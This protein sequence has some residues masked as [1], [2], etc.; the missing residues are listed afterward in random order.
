[1][2]FKKGAPRPANAGIKKGQT[3]AESKKRTVREIVE[4]CLGKTIPERL[5]E[6]GKNHPDKEA[7]ILEGLMPYTY[8]RLAAV[9]VKAEVDV[10]T[11]AVNDLVEKLE[12]LARLN[13]PA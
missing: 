6:I 8:P 12:K 3:H 9:E 2:A 1:M 4:A 11:E 5:L 10:P 7:D 13:G